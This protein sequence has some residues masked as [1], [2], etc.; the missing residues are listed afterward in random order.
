[1]LRLTVRINWYRRLPYV[2]DE[3][4]PKPIPLYPGSTV[5]TLLTTDTSFYWVLLHLTS[6]RHICGYHCDR[7]VGYVATAIVSYFNTF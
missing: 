1:M 6:C 7:S 4:S 3:V 5:R 2:I